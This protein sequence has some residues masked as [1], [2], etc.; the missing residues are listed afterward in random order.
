MDYQ[1]SNLPFGIAAANVL[2]DD[3]GSHPLSEAEKED[4]I[5][6]YKDADSEARKER[7]RNA[8][9]GEDDMRKALDG[10]GIG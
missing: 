7:I 2:E 3:I 1:Y 8:V 6:K 5:F 9:S 10:P 4:L